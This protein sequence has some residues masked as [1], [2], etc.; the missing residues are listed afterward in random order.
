MM[1]RSP[2]GP[3]PTAAHL[4]KVEKSLLTPTLSGLLI[5]NDGTFI[6]N[7]LVFRL[8]LNSFHHLNFLKNINDNYRNFAEIRNYDLR[9]NHILIMNL[10]SASESEIQI[11]IF[12]CVLENSLRAF[13][14]MNYAKIINL[15]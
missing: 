7:K 4:V 8:F 1:M 13:S 14:T 5:L 3:R 2:A 9:R 12:T 6:Q 11:K 10:I 15:S